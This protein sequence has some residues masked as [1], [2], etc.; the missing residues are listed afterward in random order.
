MFD[1]FYVTIMEDYQGKSVLVF[2]AGSILLIVEKI[3]DLQRGSNMTPIL[4]SIFLFINMT[5]VGFQN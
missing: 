1:V 3:M 2:S 4:S 5:N